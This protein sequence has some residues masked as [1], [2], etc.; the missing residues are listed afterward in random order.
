MILIISNYFDNH[1]AIAQSYNTISFFEAWQQWWHR[2]D[3]SNRHLYIMPIQWWARISKIIALLAATVLFL[4]L[5]GHDQLRRLSVSSKRTSR[6][7][8]KGL[9]RDIIYRYYRL[10][11][12]LI[13][14]YYRKKRA[15]IPSTIRSSFALLFY[16]S[17][18]LFYLLSVAHYTFLLDESAL[19]FTN[20]S[21]LWVIVASIIL[22]LGYFIVPAV[23]LIVVLFVALFLFVSYGVLFSALSYTTYSIC[24][25]FLSFC[26]WLLFKFLS[27][28][29][30]HKHIH[31]R[32]RITSFVL[33][34]I[35]FHFDLLAS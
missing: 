27:W 32:I 23:Y 24:L 10:L 16:S 3:I 6:Q 12:V 33:I 29:T 1:V 35:A 20:R 9:F 26:C 25:G 18:T 7:I 22:A 17:F 31:D 13:R 28:Q 8:K 30:S 21:M 14:R 2:A 4:D 5:V 15:I 11:R 19:F 34:L